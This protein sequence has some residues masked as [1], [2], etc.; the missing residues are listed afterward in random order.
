M[1]AEHDGEW[2]LIFAGYAQQV[3]DDMAQEAGSNAFS[4]F[5]HRETLRCLSDQIAVRVPAARR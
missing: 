3:L 5:V 4:S 1:V 2:P